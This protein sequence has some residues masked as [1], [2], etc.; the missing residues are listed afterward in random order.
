MNLKTFIIRPNGKYQLNEAVIK[1]MD[2]YDSYNKIEY[3]VKIYDDL[4]DLNCYNYI[5]VSGKFVTTKRWESFGC[6]VE[7]EVI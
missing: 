6:N 3:G 7:K 2:R 5:K 4:M 1:E